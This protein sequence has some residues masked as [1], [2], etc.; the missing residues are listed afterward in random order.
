M[1]IKKLHDKLLKI[2]NKLWVELEKKKVPG[3][4]P[5]REVCNHLTD[6][7]TYLEEIKE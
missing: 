7:Y 4:D 1:N 6:A 5:L 3:D 2:E